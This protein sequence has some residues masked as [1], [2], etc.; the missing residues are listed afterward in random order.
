MAG[1][2]LNIFLSSSY[3]P[4]LNV[5]LNV[6]NDDIDGLK[7]PNIG[8]TLEFFYIQQV[9]LKF[10]LFKLFSTLE[11]GDIVPYS[12]IPIFF[13]FPLS[14]TLRNVYYILK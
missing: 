3:L 6:F 14:L 9:L 8:P 5:V 4:S 10:D 2:L 7:P 12:A 13:S 11:L 1:C